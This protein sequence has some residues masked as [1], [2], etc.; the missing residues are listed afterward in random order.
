MLRGVPAAGLDWLRAAG[1][2]RPF[3]RGAELTP[4]IAS[5]GVFI[6]VLGTVRV[7]A[8]AAAG[9]A[10]SRTR[11]LPGVHLSLTA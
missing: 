11:R 5:G 8:V 9:A 2:L 7:R 1:D 6:V 3:A 4:L 10:G